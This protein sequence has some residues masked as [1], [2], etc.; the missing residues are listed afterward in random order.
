MANGKGRERQ[1]SMLTNGSYFWMRSLGNQGMRK[2]SMP[3]Q[4]DGGWLS[5]LNGWY[6]ANCQEK[7]AILVLI[8][9]TV[10]LERFLNGWHPRPQS[11][12]GWE[13]GEPRNEN[14]PP[15][16]PALGEAQ[17]RESLLENN[18]TSLSSRRARP[19]CVF[20]AGTNLN[21]K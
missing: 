5:I 2:S 14:Q 16:L 21:G 15:Q 12:L 8:L 18:L 6:R 11:Q 1:G 9:P 17:P 13:A 19:I 4:R 10:Q 20:Q 7:R 3:S